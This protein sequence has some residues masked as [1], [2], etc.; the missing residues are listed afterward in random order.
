MSETLNLVN[1]KDS[2]SCKYEISKFPDGQQSLKVITPI[3][4]INKHVTIKSRFNSFQDLELIVCA[5]QALRGIGVKKISL[6]IPYCLGGRS[7]RKFSEGGINYIKDV[8]APIINSQ[9]Y[10]KVEIMDP[11]SDVLEACINNFEKVSTNKLIDFVLRDYFRNVKGVIKIDYIKLLLLSPDAGAYKK[12]YGVAEYMGYK[13]DIIVASKYRNIETGKIE[14]T[15]VPFPNNDFLDKDIF[16]VDDICDGGRTFTEVAKAIKENKKYTG[17]IY[18]VVTHGIFSAGFDFL[19]QYF[20]GIYT[21]NSVK[22]IQDGT[23]V[24]T[25]SRHKTIHSFVKQLNLF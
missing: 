7:D 10:H 20:D 19:V 13:G 16:I 21:T 1:P 5:T 14:K 3:N 4:E 8:I 23:I 12:I 22:D 9:N 15:I 24:D 25:F 18:L 2:L 6:Y 17:K 11:H